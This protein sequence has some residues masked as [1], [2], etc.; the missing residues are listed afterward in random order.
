MTR[1]IQVRVVETDDRGER[2]ELRCWNITLDGKRVRWV[3]G[4]AKG[5]G[6][7][8]E[9]YRFQDVLARVG[10]EAHGV[11]GAPMADPEQRPCLDCEHPIFMHKR[12]ASG[13]YR[14]SS[15]GC[16]C[17]LASIRAT[18]NAA[19]CPQS[20][21]HQ[22]KDDAKPTGKRRCTLDAN[23]DGGCEFGPWIAL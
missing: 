17:E 9:A 2:T 14:C 3:G 22:D 6:P 18:V 5:Q 8:H 20:E 1:M 19:R 15:S 23:H 12:H 4:D 7:T 11:W 13:A 21:L 16:G 10:D